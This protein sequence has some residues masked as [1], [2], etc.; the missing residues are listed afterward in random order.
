MVGVWRV[1][2]HFRHKSATFLSRVKA[3]I[4]WMN[5]EISLA[6]LWAKPDEFHEDIVT[7]VFCIKMP[8]LWKSFDEVKPQCIPCNCHHDL[9]VFNRMLGPFKGFLIWSNPD[10]LIIRGKIKLSLIEDD[11]K[12][13][14]LMFD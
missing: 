3:C 11:N 13:L 9:L 14:I 5:N 7:I 10:L 12:V 6:K 4:V 1:T 2:A 8:A